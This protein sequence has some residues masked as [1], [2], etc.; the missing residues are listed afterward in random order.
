MMER[1][2]KVTIKKVRRRSIRVPLF[3]VRAQCPICGQYV[4]AVTLAEAGAVL[5]V[6]VLTVNQLVADG[7]VHALNTASGGLRVCKDSLFVQSP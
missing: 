4:E 1:S 3:V 5:E 2:L 6:D 7:Q